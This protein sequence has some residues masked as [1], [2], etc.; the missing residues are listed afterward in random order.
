MRKPKED[1]GV[2]LDSVGC[3]SA[4][5]FVGM[6]LSACVQM[7]TTDIARLVE[8]LSATA[9][10]KDAPVYAAALK[11]LQRK[12]KNVSFTAPIASCGRVKLVPDLDDVNARKKFSKLLQRAKDLDK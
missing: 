5:E 1:E 11:L 12:I 4:L 7:T 2:K 9:P 10:Q 6:R 3:V 8:A